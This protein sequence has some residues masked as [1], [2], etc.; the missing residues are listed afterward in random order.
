MYDAMEDSHAAP[1]EIILGNGKLTAI[2]LVSA[3]ICGACFGFG[4]SL[5][6]HT[7]AKA[8]EVDAPSFSASAPGDASDAKPS[9]ASSSDAP[10]STSAIKEADL[11]PSRPTANAAGSTAVNAGR[12]RPAKNGIAAAAPLPVAAA[13]SSDAALP[14]HTF[15]VQVAAISRQGDA[16]I[17]VA[18]LHRKGY[19]VSAVA[20]SQDHLVHVQIGPFS[21]PKDAAAMRDRLSNDGYLAIVK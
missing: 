18:A 14:T 7:A 8:A 19:Q 17:L 5:G 10:A 12:T 3:V 4:Y 21:N 20:D 2:F 16:D 1:G 15:V 11:A 13:S 6:R 9:P